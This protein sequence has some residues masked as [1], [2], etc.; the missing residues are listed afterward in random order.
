MVI[1]AHISSNYSVILYTMT[2]NIGQLFRFHLIGKSPAD[3]FH[4]IYLMNDVYPRNGD[5]DPCPNR[6]AGQVSTTSLWVALASATARTS[7]GL[8]PT[9]WRDLHVVEIRLSPSSL[10]KATQ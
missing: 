5:A 7:A 2:I 10:E 9:V 8:Y 1:R 3:E 4:T 6:F